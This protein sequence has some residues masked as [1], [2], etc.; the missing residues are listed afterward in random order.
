MIWLGPLLGLVLGF[1]MAGGGAPGL[2]GAGVGV[3]LGRQFDRIL[4]LS[5]GVYFVTHR[6]PH[7]PDQKIQQAFFQAI[8]VCLGRV[9]KCDG[10]VVAGEIEWARAVMDRMGLN[11]EKRNEAANLFERGKGWDY[12]VFADLKRLREACGRRSALSAIFMEMLVQGALVD[13][14][15]NP[16]EWATL[17][18]I[19]ATLNVSRE[20]LERM[21]RAADAFHAWSHHRGDR[22]DRYQGAGPTRDALQDAYAILGI[23]NTAS[24]VDVKRAWR[25]QMSKHHPDKLAA[26]GLPEEMK[27]LATEKTQAI[28]AAYEEIMRVRQVEQS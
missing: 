7:E 3:W 8:F 26:K 23:R 28:Q 6:Q 22:G 2:I 10:T 27:P 18:N 11:S 24:L 14:Q 4:Q 25:R 15:L 16:R 5:E 21:V 9:A 1:A 19:A 20:S 17:Q 13:G 12:D